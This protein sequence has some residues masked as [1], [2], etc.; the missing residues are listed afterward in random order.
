M[1]THWFDHKQQKT[2]SIVF[3]FP[4][5]SISVAPAIQTQIKVSQCPLQVPTWWPVDVT[6]LST[7]HPPKLNYSSWEGR[8]GSWYTAPAAGGFLSHIYSYQRVSL[9]WYRE[10]SITRGIETGATHGL[11]SFP[12]SCAL[13]RKILTQSSIWGIVW[14]E[15]RKFIAMTN[16]YMYIIIRPC[17]H[18]IRS[19]GL[20]PF[21]VAFLA[22]LWLKSREQSFVTESGHW[23]AS[24]DNVK[25]TNL[26]AAVRLGYCIRITNLTIIRF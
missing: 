2:R 7:H 12:V 10:T 6:H 13:L 20:N 22:Y 15:E 21:S 4:V 14:K 19:V 23:C 5:F 11:I 24:L 8:G 17:I 16:H 1:R 9:T 18:V 3:N 25:V 26:M